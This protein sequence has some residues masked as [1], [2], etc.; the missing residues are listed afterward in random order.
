MLSQLNRLEAA[1]S[2]P[3]EVYG[4][5][6]HV[7]CDRVV[8]IYQTE[9]VEVQALQGLDLL[10]GR[11]E[12]M[13]IVGAS[14]SGKSTLL[15]ILSGLD[16]PTAGRATVAGFDL[17]AL[18]KRDR[19]R[20]RRATVGFIWQNTAKN[21]LPFLSAA[22]NVALPMAFAG[23]GRRARRARALELLE[24]L[25]VADCRDRRPTQL[26]GGQQQRVAI[27]TALAN[28]PEVILADEPTGELDSATAAQVFEALRGANRELGVT[29]L[30]VTHDKAVSEHVGRTVEIRDGRISTET[31]RAGL[32]PAADAD[33]ADASGT[34]TGTGVV[35]EQYAVLD[36]AGRVQLPREYT[37]AAGLRDRVRLT[38]DP[39]HVGVWPGHTRPPAPP[40]PAPI[41]SEDASDD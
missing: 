38:L 8:R 35:A 12:L 32:D 34:G 14:G 33:G 1:V 7:V 10:V 22:D 40:A 3:A 27:A 39:D 36:R 19:L 26:S 20:Y 6:A 15:G 4:G 11:G 5:D 9:D 37:D 13:A 31:L 21:L 30:V 2:G 25:G 18:S 41:S 17:G 24:L 16:A 23:G 29:V 28:R